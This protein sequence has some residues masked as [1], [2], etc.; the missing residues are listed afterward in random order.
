MIEDPQQAVR[1]RSTPAQRTATTSRS[2]G[3]NGT[4]RGSKGG[5]S[6]LPYLYVEPRP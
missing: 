5:H 6:K 1:A 3:A 4:R 2:I